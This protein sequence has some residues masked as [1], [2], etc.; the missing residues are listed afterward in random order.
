[1]FVENDLYFEEVML[2]VIF[3]YFCYFLGYVSFDGRVFWWGFFMNFL[4][5]NMFNF[6]IEICFVEGL[7]GMGFMVIFCWV[8]V[9]IICFWNMC[10]LL[11][12]F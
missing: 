5:F 9:V 10:V 12:F 4:V 7:L 2:E 6:M 3:C 11:I 8:F 1:M